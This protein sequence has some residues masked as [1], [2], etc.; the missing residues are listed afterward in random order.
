[1]KRNTLTEKRDKAILADYT[2]GITSTSDLAERYFMQEASVKKIL[3][4]QGI[5]PQ[6]ALRDKQRCLVKKY[7]LAGDDRSDIATKAGVAVGTVDKWARE[8]GLRCE[9]KIAMTSVHPS[10]TGKVYKVIGQL[11]HTAFPLSV[12]GI[13]LNCSREYVRQVQAHCILENIPLHKS[14][15][16]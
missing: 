16:T 13:E 8:M 2:G 9:R 10:A 6:K 5:D 12:I 4:K 14:R 15:N 11:I 1:M 3:K 7:I